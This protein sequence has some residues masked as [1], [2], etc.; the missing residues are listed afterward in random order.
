MCV[1]PVT[2]PKTVKNRIHLDLTS[3]A[4]DRD[5]EIEPLLPL[6]ARRGR[7]RAARHRALDRTGRP[8]GQRVLH[9]TPEGNAHPLRLNATRD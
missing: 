9:D 4:Q 7:H 5:Q 2:D 8:R 1:M 6:G 3:S